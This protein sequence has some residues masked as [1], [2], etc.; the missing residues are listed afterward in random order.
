VIDESLA[1]IAFPG[2]SAV[3][4]LLR[5]EPLGHEDP[6]TEILGVAAHQRLHDLTRPLLPQIFFPESDWWSASLVVRTEGDPRALA[7]P[8]RET[9]RS[10]ASGVAVEDV[11]PM[12]ELVAAARA[13]ARLSLVLLVGFGLFSVVLAAVG[14]FGVVSY[15]V[16]FR[17]QELSI[18]MALGATPGGIRRKVLGEGAALV[19][20]AVSLGL[21]GA[22]LLGHFLAGFL[23]GVSPV[24]PWTYAAVAL[25]LALVALAACWVPAERA[26]RFD[27]AQSLRADSL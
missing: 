15:A 24:D 25:T 20:L 12:E 9:I 21:A 27:P 26:T 18:R 13:P 17:K 19:A 11:A 1:E 14:L 5:V 4:E 22:A 8:L 23:Y 16:S 10:L 2:R 7:G 6:F 3:G